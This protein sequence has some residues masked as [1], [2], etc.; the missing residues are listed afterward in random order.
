MNVIPWI[1]VGSWGVFLL[2]WIVS[3]FFAKRDAGRSPWRRFALLRIIVA[4]MVVGWVWETSS[5]GAITRHTRFL[6]PQTSGMPGITAAALCALGIGLAIWARV[7]LGR[8]WSAVPSIKEGHEL[9]TS[10]PYAVIRHPI[11]TGILLSVLGSTII[12]PVW[13]AIFAVTVGM[14]LW[15]VHVEENLMMRQFPGQYPAYKKRT[16]ALIP[17]VF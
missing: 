4:F 17:F 13:L 16:W 10:G 15:R 12:S 3:A 6:L 7:H 9:V 2:F 11:Y 8:N 1:I 14:F 5:F